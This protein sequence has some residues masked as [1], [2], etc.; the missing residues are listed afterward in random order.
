MPTKHPR[1]QF[2]PSDR[3]A[4]LLRELSDLTGKSQSGLVRELMDEAV[5]ALEMTLEAF[6]TLKARPDQ[7]RAAVARLAAQAHMTIAQASLDLDT[8]LKPGRKPGR[9]KGGGPRKPG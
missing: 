9:T 5:P 3:V 2:T 7:A 4:P 8:S 1:I 6:R